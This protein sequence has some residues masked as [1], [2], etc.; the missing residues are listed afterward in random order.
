MKEPE[1]FFG[2]VLFALN[3]A[4][5]SDVAYLYTVFSQDPPDEQFAVAA[6]RVLLAAH[7]RDPESA[8][9]VAQPANPFSERV[10]LRDSPIVH[11]TVLVIELVSLRPA[12]KLPA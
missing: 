6:R 4:R 11:P 12:A 7:Q 1:L 9:S 2:K 10:G 5:A 3:D 8:R